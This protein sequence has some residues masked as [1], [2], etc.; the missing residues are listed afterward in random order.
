M[1]II[2]STVLGVRS[3]VWHLRLD[4]QSPQFFLFPMIHIAD[5]N[6]YEEVVKRLENCDLIFCVR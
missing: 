5:E 2:D 4:D 3:A 6:F 1:Q